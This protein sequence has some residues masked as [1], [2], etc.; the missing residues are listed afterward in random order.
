MSKLKIGVICSMRD[1]PRAAIDKAHGLGIEGAQ[2]S[3]WDPALYTDAF[4]DEANAATRDTGVE[5]NTVWSGGPGGG[6]WNFYEG[7]ETIGIVPRGRRCQR[8]EGL[9]A[10]ARFAK[11]IG[12]ESITT[13][14]GF[15]PENPNDPVFTETVNA[16]RDVAGYCDELGVGFWFETG[17]ETPVT[18]LRTIEEIGLDN[19]GVNLDPANLVLYG[20]ANPVDSLD[21]F[22][23]YVKGVHAKDGL[24]PTNGRDLGLETPLGEGKVD[25][26]V[27]IKRLKD[28]FGFTGHL[29]IEREISGDK[30]I[31]D[32]KRAIDLL[33]PLC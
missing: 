25:F 23:Q 8:I 14:V 28:E 29:T 33:R 3:C 7:P 32:I 4:V 13:H 2:L 9:K 17:Q 6:M 22:G 15:I 10:G 5:V 31:E 18:I 1:G 30:Q 24:Y 27:L 12:V 26:P 21:V 20:K 19:L 11:A 16:L